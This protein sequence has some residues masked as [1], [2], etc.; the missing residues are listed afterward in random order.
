MLILSVL[1]ASAGEAA[2]ARIDGWGT[3]KDEYQA[4][5]TVSGFI[6]I[7]NEGATSIRDIEIEVRVVKET[8]VGGIEVHRKTYRAAD[9][10]RGFSIPPGETVL[11]HF[12]PAGQ[13]P[14]TVPASALAKGKYH[15]TGRLMIGGKEFGRVEKRI[16]IVR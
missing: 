11:F 8:L 6:R 15:F 3:N 14:F 7:I 4:G 10:I 16:R 13:P 5:D 9:F 12:P 1:P 2:A